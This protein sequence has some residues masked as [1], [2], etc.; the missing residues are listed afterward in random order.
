VRQS[1]YS[2]KRLEN[3]DAFL[4]IKGAKIFPNDPRHGHMQGD[5]EILQSH[6]L[7]PLGRLQKLQQHGRQA[8]IIA[9]PVRFNCESF[10]F[11][12]LTEVAN[13][14]CDDRN[15]VLARQVRYS[16]GSCRRRVGHHGYSGAA[17]EI[18]NRRFWDIA[19]KFDLRIMAVTFGDRFHV[20]RRVGMIS[21]CHHQAYPRH[22]Q[23][24]RPKSL[25]HRLQPLVG[26]PLTKGKHALSRWVTPR[27]VGVF[28]TTGKD[29][30]RAKVHMLGAIF[31]TENSTVRRQQNGNRI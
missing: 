9:G 30:M 8:N 5:G 28:R 10:L 6:G 29:S 17:E 27:K 15:T 11:C 24:N 2:G 21:T 4:Q 18:A 16:A 3:F 13:V 1:A 14:G 19:G 23:G 22:F 20:A 7:L 12:Q 26:P 25:N 31:F